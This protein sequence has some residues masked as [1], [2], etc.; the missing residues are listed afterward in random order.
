MT[1]S[2]LVRS[3]WPVVAAAL[4]TVPA[5]AAD[6]LPFAA[7]AAPAMASE[8]G[9]LLRV[10]LAL[11]LVLALL[12]GGAWLLKRLSV[13]QVAASQRIRV[14]GQISLGARERAVL[15]SVAGRDV[16]LGVAPGHVSTLLVS[17]GTVEQP[18]NAAADPNLAAAL[19]P[20]FKD[21]LRRSLGR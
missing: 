20:T 7:P 3:V 15:V 6:T 14:L 17:E 1:L 21:I 2:R 5:H 9:S 19:R 16:L 12:L 13:G 8:S 11:L 4:L 10:P 18:L